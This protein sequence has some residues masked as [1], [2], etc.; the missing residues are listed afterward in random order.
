MNRSDIAHVVYT[1][2]GPRYFTA[3]KNDLRAARELADTEGTLVLDWE[4]GDTCVC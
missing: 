1:S 2:R 3:T 4:T